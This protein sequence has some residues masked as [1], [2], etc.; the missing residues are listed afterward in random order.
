[1]NQDLL[2]KAVIKITESEI[3]ELLRNKNLEVQVLGSILKD[4]TLFNNIEIYGKELFY[5]KVHQE[6]FEAMKR[7]N[8]KGQA[9]D[10]ITVPEAAKEINQAIPISYLAEL[11]E[12]AAIS[13]SNFETHLNLL[14]DYKNKR[15]IYNSM[16]SINLANS[17]ESISND[18]YKLLDQILITENNSKNTK[19][20]LFDYIEN[21]YAPKKDMGIK[22]GLD[23]IDRKIGGL[24]S[25]QLITIAG[26]TGMG[27]SI[28][29]SQII[30]NMLRINKKISL[31][32][33]EMSRE[34][35]FNKLSSNGC[36]IDFNKIFTGN[37]TDQEKEQITEF[38]SKFLAKKD[39]EIY[40]YMDD[41]NKIINQI[42]KD[43][44]Q[45]KVD[46]VFIDL[47]NR[48]TDSSSKEQQNRAVLL[49]SLT[50]KLKLLAGKLRIPIVITAQ[51]NR[52]I[53]QRRDKE[54]ALSDIKE[55]GGIAEDSDYVVA[56]YRN[57]DL[58]D[59]KV[60]EELN[61]AGKLNYN[62]KDAEVN[63]ECIEIHM[64]KGRNVNG[65]K[66]GFYW[67]PKYQRIC[68]WAK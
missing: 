43:K 49:A 12:E 38:V 10:I 42:K 35:I 4:G 37:I 17:C 1:M 57:K 15:A 61:N 30:L 27:K 5:H 34:E 39:L 33:L 66:A 60:R 68:N 14:L 19:E 62:V 67:D 53:E 47:I 65:F 7:A 36:T 6:I 13:T 50:R 25:G 56:V 21:L 2:N 28:L 63:P 26:Y 20:S 46:I 23:T 55:S 45:N 22:L 9:I 59:P 16:R 51:I 64:L 48:V 3:L 41:I 31:Y 40:E 29:V 32:T 54:P 24:L 58:E 11:S 18:L 52:A 44:L 8:R